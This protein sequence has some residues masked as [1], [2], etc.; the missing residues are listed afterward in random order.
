MHVGKQ[1]RYFR[2]NEVLVFREEDESIVWISFT[3]AIYFK[4]SISETRSLV[5]LRT[6]TQDSGE[7]HPM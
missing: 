7:Q 1:P 4:T 5:I 3:K 2:R 6:E